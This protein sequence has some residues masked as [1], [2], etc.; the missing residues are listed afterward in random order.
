M[1]PIAML[2]LLGKK[3]F[4]EFTGWS[5]GQTSSEIQKFDFNSFP[6]LQK[7]SALIKKDL[8]TK[9]VEEVSEEYGIDLKI[10]ELLK[11]SSGK[12]N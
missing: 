9:P 12:L 2:M 7:Y 10:A 6:F 4:M 1:D 8:E 5:E 11:K 3:D